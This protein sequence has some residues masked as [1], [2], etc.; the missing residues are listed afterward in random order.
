[1]HFF[2]T[3]PGA[4]WTC[5]LPVPATAVVDVPAGLLQPAP[6]SR[7]AKTSGSS[8]ADFGCEA[9]QTGD[10]V[11]VPEVSGRPSLRTLPNPSRISAYFFSSPAPSPVVRR[12]PQ[13]LLGRVW[14]GFCPPRVCPAQLP[15]ERSSAGRHPPGLGRITGPRT[16]R[17]NA[18]SVAEV[19]HTKTRLMCQLDAPAPPWAC[20]ATGRRAPCTDDRN[21]VYSLGF[22]LSCCAPM[23]TVREVAG[24]VA[25]K[26]LVSPA[27]TV[28]L[29]GLPHPS[30]LTGA[31]SAGPSWPSSARA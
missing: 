22:P 16:N 6:R 18:A 17:S 26:V 20:G 14:T 29:V 27:P 21:S 19:L 8:E 10:L 25:G 15:R 3:P 12:A 28:S 9:Q 13:H 23:P 5:P 4:G 1:M 24:Y 30:R 2:V 7:P 11:P 31:S